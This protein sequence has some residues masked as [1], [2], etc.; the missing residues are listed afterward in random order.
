MNTAL[1]RKVDDSA[2]I[3]RRYSLFAEGVAQLCPGRFHLA[4]RLMTEQDAPQLL[5][6]IIARD[7]FLL[8]VGALKIDTSGQD[9]EITDKIHP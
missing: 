2:L 5:P 9:A 3:E 4:R 6:L 7:K 8:R 1:S